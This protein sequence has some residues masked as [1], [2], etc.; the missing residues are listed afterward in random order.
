MKFK[1]LVLFYIL[2]ALAACTDNESNS[3]QSTDD[4]KY[5]GSYD[6]T[7][8]NHSFEDNTFTTEIEDV[9]IESD[10]ADA[11]L[12]DGVSLPI[13]ED[14]TT[15]PTSIEN[16]FYN[17]CFKADSLYLLTY[18]HVPGLGIQCYIKGKKR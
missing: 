14:G 7:K 10:G 4:S 18:P 2:L 13:M 12:L 5:A 15:G 17:L 8:S 9:I 1:S 6:C 16:N 3:S 11:I